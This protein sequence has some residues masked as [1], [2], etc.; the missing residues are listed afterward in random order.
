MNVVECL[1]EYVLFCRVNF[2]NGGYFFFFGGGCV[3]LRCWC[4]D[5]LVV[6]VN[7]DDFYGEKVMCCLIVFFG[8]YLFYFSNYWW[9]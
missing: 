3:F 2:K 9:W 5:F 1:F 6:D 4:V 8:E 7:S